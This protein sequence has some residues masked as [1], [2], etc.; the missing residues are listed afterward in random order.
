MN[1]KDEHKSLDQRAYEVIKDMILSGQLNPNTRLTEEK[2][3]RELGVSRTPI[4]NAF[5]RLKAEYLLEDGP[6]Q[7]IR[8]KLSS[9]DEAMEVYE[10]REVLEGL[11]AKKAVRLLDQDAVE[12]MIRDFERLQSQ[13]EKMD[14]QEFERLNFNFHKMIVDSYGSKS[15][16]R[17]IIDLMMKTRAF[18]Q[19]YKV[20]YFYAE[21]SVKEHL[22]VLYAIKNHDEEI[23]EGL[24]RKHLRNIRSSFLKA[25]ERIPNLKKKTGKNSPKIK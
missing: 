1:L 8:A 3:A 11:A 25:I 17:L 18:H 24:H 9:I 13:G 19:K 10:V 6:S 16:A 23:V 4:K 14:A 2:M 21:N 12:N 5:I 15:I 20:Q 22:D 7:G